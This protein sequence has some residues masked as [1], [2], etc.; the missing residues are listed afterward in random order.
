MLHGC[1]RS[2]PLSTGR[3]PAPRA[4]SSP[5]GDPQPIV[6][7]PDATDACA[8]DPDAPPARPPGA[9]LRSR[10][11]LSTYATAV[12]GLARLLY[13]V[14]IGHLGSRELLGQTNTSLSLSVLASQLWAVPGLRGRHPVRRGAGRRSTTREGAAIVA[15]HIATRTARISLVLPDRRSPSSARSSLG[16]QPGAHHRHGASLAFTYSMYTTLRG[17]QYGALRFRHVA[18]WD[19]IAGA[20]PS[21]P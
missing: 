7:H 8:L 18:V 12:Q 4:S 1:R 11:A 10:A 19:T 20:P 13:G 3:T 21:W 9:S 16:L 5:S 14:L 2:R 17:I 6:V 15:R